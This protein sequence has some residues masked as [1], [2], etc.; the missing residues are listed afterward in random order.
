[1]KI[2]VDDKRTPVD[3]N[4]TIVRSY[5]DF[6]F[7]INQSFDKINLISFDYLL[8]DSNAPE[9]TGLDCAKY[10]IDYCNMNHKLLPTILAHDDFIIGA[11][12]IVQFINHH[13]LFN[14]KMPNCRWYHIENI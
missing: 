7:I 14:E 13:L 1:V 11:Q 9:K 4:W 5:H 12:E 3:N 2:Y 10:L 6:L 8:N